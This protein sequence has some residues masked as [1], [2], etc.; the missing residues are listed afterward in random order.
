AEPIAAARRTPAV[1]GPHSFGLALAAHAMI[2]EVVSPFA[3]FGGALT[4]RLAKHGSDNGRGA[5]VGLSALYLS[6]DVL[7]SEDVRVRWTAGA[8]TVCPGWVLG[9]AV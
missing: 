3:S 1:P 2:A 8:L 6:N 4:V 7:T 9:H 5:S